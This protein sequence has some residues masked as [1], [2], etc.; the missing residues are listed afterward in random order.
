MERKKII[1]IFS[2]DIQ[3]SKVKSEAGTTCFVNALNRSL[4]ED[5]ST[6]TYDN[7]S[8]VIYIL[9]IMVGPLSLKFTAI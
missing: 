4:A 9:K 5:P 7:G 3:V 1:L 2:Y 6:I 8:R